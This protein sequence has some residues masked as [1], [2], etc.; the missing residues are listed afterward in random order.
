MSSKL[1]T[2]AI[3]FHI[4]GLSSPRRS[5]LKATRATALHTNKPVKWNP[6]H[7][8][9]ASTSPL[10]FSLLRF[11]T[12]AQISHTHT[13]EEFQHKESGPPKTPTTPRNSLCLGL[14]CI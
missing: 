7:P 9:H 11:V 4:Q 5:F 6:Y 8:H 12:K 2:S 3:F 13:H 14:S 1:R 10:V